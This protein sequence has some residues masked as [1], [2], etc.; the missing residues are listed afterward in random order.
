MSNSFI[1]SIFEDIVIFLW[2]FG[3]LFIICA[4]AN[5]LCYRK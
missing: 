1:Q 2:Y 5:V 3:E 4:L